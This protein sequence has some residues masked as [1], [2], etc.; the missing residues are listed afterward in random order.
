MAKYEKL[1]T[2]EVQELMERKRRSPRAEERRRIMEEL[3]AFLL[4]LEP[5][6]GAVVELEPGEKRQTVKNRIKRAAE[7][8][9]VE[10]EFIRKRKK[11][12]FRV[13]S[14][15]KSEASEGEE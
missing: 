14:K 9:G 15:E 5:G 12:Y 13:I 2:D 7:L 10:I 4:S 11:I 8:A 3:V 6:E 1:S